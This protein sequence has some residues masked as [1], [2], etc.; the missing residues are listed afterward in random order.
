M[1]PAADQG[2]HDAVAEVAVSEEHVSADHHVAG[3]PADHHE[4]RDA[5]DSDECAEPLTKRRRRHKGPE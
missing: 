3:L 5:T 1:P 4:G 2:A